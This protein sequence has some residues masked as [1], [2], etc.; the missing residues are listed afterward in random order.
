MFFYD[1]PII[2]GVNLSL[3][4]SNS[5]SSSF[6]LSRFSINS[7]SKAL[8]FSLLIESIFSLKSI[9]GRMEF[10]RILKDILLILSF[11]VFFLIF[12]I[13]MSFILLAMV[14]QDCMI[15]ISRRIGESICQNKQ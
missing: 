12:T 8:S 3:C 1:S 11:S 10:S 14:I 9:G 15:F 7:S 13:F 5:S 2:P 6:K 4:F